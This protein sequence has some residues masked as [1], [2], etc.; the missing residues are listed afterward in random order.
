M[1]LDQVFSSELGLTIVGT[2]FGAV[3][4]AFRSSEWYGRLRRQRFQQG[5][6]ALEAGVEETYRTYVQAL[7][8]ARADGTLT[9]EEKRQAR[10]LAKERAVAIAQCEGVDLL[11]AVGAEYIDLWIAKLVKK[12]KRA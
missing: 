1:F 6:L 7:K 10:A 9:E 8:E 5:L 12:L 3:W 4:A 11:R 2:I